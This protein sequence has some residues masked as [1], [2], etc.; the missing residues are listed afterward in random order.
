MTA[1]VFSVDLEGL[2]EVLAAVRREVA[3]KLRA[4]ALE[5]S[6]GTRTG[7]RVA[8]RLQEIALSVEMGR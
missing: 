6:D 4:A 7:R 8:Q 3:T 2:P 5:E 1:P